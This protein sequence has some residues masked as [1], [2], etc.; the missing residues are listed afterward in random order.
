MKRQ[1][2]IILIISTQVIAAAC[3]ASTPT[4]TVREIA[5]AIKHKDREKLKHNLSE[6]ALGR[7]EEMGKQQG[8]SVD[9][10]LD[11]SLF[12]AFVYK[13]WPNPI[14]TRNETIN[15]DSATIEI[16]LGYT[17]SKLYLRKEHKEWKLDFN[18]ERISVKEGPN[19]PDSA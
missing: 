19:K 16:N 11:E 7:I 9:A 4:E 13:D 3:K 18:P 6:L 10:M 12:D 8:K 1:F 17:W 5:K 15:G 2:L 14:E